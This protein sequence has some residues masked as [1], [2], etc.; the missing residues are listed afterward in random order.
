MS[1]LIAEEAQS[2]HLAGVGFIPVFGLPL[3]PNS[4]L[5]PGNWPFTVSS[6]Y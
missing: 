1:P 6:L 4:R 2:G 3:L 5:R